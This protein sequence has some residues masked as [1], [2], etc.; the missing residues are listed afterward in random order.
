MARKSMFYY[1]NIVYLI[2]H[3]FIKQLLF[4]LGPKINVMKK[5]RYSR[6]SFQK[7]AFM[8]QL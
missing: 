6:V 8:D 1:K 5:I 7:A 3:K 4:E 2:T